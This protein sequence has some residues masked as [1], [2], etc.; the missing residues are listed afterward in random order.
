MLWSLA[1]CGMVADPPATTSDASDTSSAPIAR[2]DHEPTASSTGVRKMVKT[3]D[4][5]KQQ[6]TEEQYYVTRKK[7]TERPFTGK[8]WDNKRDGTY[9]CVCCD[10][11][12]FDS[13]TKYESG[14]GWP[15]FWDPVSEQNIETEEDRGLFRVRTEVHCRRCDAHLGHVFED[16]PQPTGLRYCINSASLTFEDRVKTDNEQ[17]T[18]Q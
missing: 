4:E 5:W 18:T 6:L 11:P 1:G 12:L 2:A 16:G 9:R 3:N 13:E 14:T 8:L 10:D 17:A 15:S 7:G